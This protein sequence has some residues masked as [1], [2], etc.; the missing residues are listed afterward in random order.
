MLH[1][2]KMTA[3]GLITPVKAPM[4]PQNNNIPL[5]PLIEGQAGDF[6]SLPKKR[7]KSHHVIS[8]DTSKCCRLSETY[9]TTFGRQLGLLLLRTFLIQARDRTLTAMR[10]LIHFIVAIFIGILYIGIGN[11]GW[12][13]FNNFR[14]IFFSIMFLMFTA[15]SSNILSCK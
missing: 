8:I 5:T 7:K 3:S 1:T 12:N 10:F 15:F 13:V 4:L 2:E 14:Y 6:T 11:D 9:A